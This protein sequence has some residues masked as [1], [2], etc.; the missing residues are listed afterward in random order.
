MYIFLKKIVRKIFP[1]RFVF[2]AEPFLRKTY[3]LFF[4]GKKFHCAI[5]GGSFHRFIKLKNGELLCARCGS[6]PR[7]RR[8]FDL[9]Q[10]EKLLE[11]NV[12]D[13]SPSRYL[14][15][16]LKKM[17]GV[18]YISSDFAHEF[19]S[20]HQFDITAISLQDNFVDL[21]ICYHILEH[22]QDD[23][24]AMAELFRVLKPGG[25]MLLQTPFREGE[26]FEDTAITSAEERLKN[27]GQEDHVRIYSVEGISGRLSQAGFQVKVLSF[28]EQPMNRSGFS[29]KET[30]V[31]CKK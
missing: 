3:S 18:G 7:D 9:L 12:L 4:L 10:K 30:I 2:K 5:C 1:Q 22:V 8:L 17:P 14:Y 15:R 16:K 11:G 29:E 20:D 6:L 26:I 28:Y 27:F 31:R 24:K 25:I 13:F 21:V 19:I 23:N